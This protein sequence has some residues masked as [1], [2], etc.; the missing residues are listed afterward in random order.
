MQKILDS[1]LKLLPANLDTVPARRMMLACGYQESNMQY[2]YQLPRT[3]GGRKGPARG[4]WQF[5]AGGGVRGV[6][7]HTA[8]RGL[9]LQVVNTLGYPWDESALWQCLETDDALAGAFARL[10]ILTDA[11]PL[12]NEQEEQL[13][14]DQYLWNWRP[15]AYANGTDS[16]R[17]ELRAKWS[18]SW[19]KACDDF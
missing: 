4:L 7:R 17:A 11:R 12:P 13:A 8:S 19:K 10:L 3:V 6:M 1:A 2:R 14:W 16:G 18:R 9:A 15:G 5:E